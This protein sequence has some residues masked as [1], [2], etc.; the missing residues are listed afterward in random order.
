M[1]KI[2]LFITLLTL[3]IAVSAQDMK[4]TDIPIEKMWMFKSGEKYKNVLSKLK[5]EFPDSKI[6]TDD[7]SIIIY[8]PTFA[9]FQFN[10]AEL[11]FHS[12]AGLWSVKF[13][14]GDLI[15]YKDSLKKSH[16]RIEDMLKSKYGEPAMITK[17]FKSWIDKGLMSI[18]LAFYNV[19]SVDGITVYM[20]SIEYGDSKI[21]SKIQQSNMDDL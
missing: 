21:Y 6:D 12:E 2:V 18:I 4:Y 15:D 5:S 19:K 8:S 1:K 9:G 10:H 17:E 20:L 11:K 16:D 7:E 3:S 14:A 13:Q